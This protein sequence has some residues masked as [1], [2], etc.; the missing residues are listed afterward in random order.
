M[1]RFILYRGSEITLSSLITEPS[2]SL[3]HQSFH[4]HEREEPL[5]GDG[6]GVA[7]YVPEMSDQPALFSAVTPAWNNTNL[8]YL[9][10]VT[11]SPCVLAHIR[12]ATPGLP[13]T[14][15]N[16]HPFLW[17]PFAFMHNGHVGGFQT[18]RRRLLERLSDEAF[19]LI[20]GSTDSET[21]FA[22]FVDHYR[23]L[24]HEDPAEKLALALA[25]AIDEVE[26]L[27]REAGVEQDS[28]LNFAV[29]DGRAA[30]VSR[31]S[32][33]APGTAP[34][35]YVH[36]GSRFVCLEDSYCMVDP[37]FGHGAVIVAS[38]RLSG[39]PYWHRVKSNHLVVVREDLDVELR[40][41]E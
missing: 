16:C 5:N 22:L 2:N 21:V 4:S 8:R 34:S 38:E 17:G 37:D 41:L 3:I 1:C 25:G 36:K 7:W 35:L 10:R 23:R 27:R 12:A 26:E 19:S 40:P 33:G 13:V 39:D 29:S 15:L 30:V 32:S 11:K 31:F 20:G 9:A 6:F 28:Q 14:R 18:L 24:D